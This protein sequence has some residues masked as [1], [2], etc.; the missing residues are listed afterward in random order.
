MGETENNVNQLITYAAN[1]HSRPGQCPE[2]RLGARAGRL[3]LVP[4]GGTEL[5]VQSR[6]AQF[7]V[8]V[9][10]GEGSGHSGY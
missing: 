2:S 8:N 3:S 1:L 6:D 4:P 7:L 9:G 10:G 5:D